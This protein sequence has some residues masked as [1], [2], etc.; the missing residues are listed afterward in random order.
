MCVCVCVCEMTA[1]PKQYLYVCVGVYVC[2]FVCVCVCTY[3]Y[4]C[5]CVCVCVCASMLIYQSFTCKMTAL[6]QIGWQLGICVKMQHVVSVWTCE[7][8]VCVCLFASYLMLIWNNCHTKQIYSKISSGKQFCFVKGYFVT[9][10]ILSLSHIRTIH[11]DKIAKLIKLLMNEGYDTK[12]GNV[13]IILSIL[14]LIWMPC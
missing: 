10:R 8:F 5:V 2:L 6:Y 4:V 13:S 12:N 7:L 11:H 3:L 1:M 14:L 9:S